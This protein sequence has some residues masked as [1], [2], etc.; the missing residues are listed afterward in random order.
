MNSAVITKAEY[1]LPGENDFSVLDIVPHSGKI[2]QEPK[3]TNAGLIYSVKADF[4]IVGTS[5]EQSYLLSQLNNRKASFRL[6]DAD[7]IIY[8]VGSENYPARMLATLDLG[9]SPGS[10]KGHRCLITLNSPER[11]QVQ[12]PV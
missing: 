11:C 9:G 10:F 7:G 3:R 4:L 8:F 6:T 1:K 12:N 5:S 2:T